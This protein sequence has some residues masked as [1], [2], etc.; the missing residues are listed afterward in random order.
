[1]EYEEKQKLKQAFWQYCIDHS[2]IQDNGYMGILFYVKDRED[3]FRRILARMNGFSRYDIE[4][5][6]T[7]SATRQQI[8]NDYF[9]N[10]KRN[11]AMNQRVQEILHGGIVNRLLYRLHKIL[12]NY[13]FKGAWQELKPKKNTQPVL[14]ATKNVQE[15]Q[16]Q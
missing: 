4:E 9:Y 13:L 12:K 2:K 5:K 10:K 15:R 6:E 11:L 16:P 14:I 3:F 1:M 8:F 7:R